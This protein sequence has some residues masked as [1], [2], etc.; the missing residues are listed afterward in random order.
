MEKEHPQQSKRVLL[1]D[2]DPSVC[3]VAKL[4][5]ERNG[6]TVDLYNSGLEAWT[7]IQSQGDCYDLMIFDYLLED[8][9][10]VVLMRQTRD[11]YPQTHVILL[12]G[13]NPEDVVPDDLWSDLKDGGLGFITKPFTVSDLLD[14]VHALI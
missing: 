3:R 12:S 14:Q 6:F 10:G 2:D 11:L 5:L 9:D 13:Y 7:V 4:I 8:M 1:L